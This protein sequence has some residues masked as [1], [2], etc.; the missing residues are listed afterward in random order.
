MIKA[1]IKS[2]IQSQIKIRL[3]RKTDTIK[4]LKKKTIKRNWEKSIENML[5]RIKKYTQHSYNNFDNKLHIDIM[6][7]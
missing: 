6:Y 4:Q 2:T 5:Q 7:I 1:T 3:L